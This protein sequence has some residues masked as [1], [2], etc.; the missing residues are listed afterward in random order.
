MNVYVINY[1]NEERKSRMI[2]RLKEIDYFQSIVFPD[3][4]NKDDVRLLNLKKGRNNID[5]RVWSIMLQH[6]DAVSHFVNQTEHQHC[7]ICEDDVLIHKQLVD[8]MPGI[9]KV[10]QSCNLD[11]L[12][13]GYLLP[14]KL[15][16]QS[17]YHKRYF[18]TVAEH[19]SLSY[20]RYED[21]IWGAQMYL[22]SR[23]YG[24]QLLQK[25]TIEYALDGDKPYNPDWTIT[26]P[27]KNKRA[28]IYPMLAL[29]E[30]VNLSN[31]RSQNDFH[32]LCHKVN[33][34]YSYI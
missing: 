2:R 8:K 1:Q 11:V 25:Y 3:E 20:H 18:K 4:V 7:I 12:M 17:E 23:K 24:K 29:E 14:F 16:F 5:L 27:D 15:D 30:G 9:L 26:K 22:I 33:Y 21:D 32:S 6:L 19:Q 10:F 34:N 13:L 31:D 28:L